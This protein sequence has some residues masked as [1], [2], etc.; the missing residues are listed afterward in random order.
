MARTFALELDE[1]NPYNNYPSP[2]N[3]S[4]IFTKLPTLYL[5]KLE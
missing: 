2:K 3:G 4:D 1:S 5:P